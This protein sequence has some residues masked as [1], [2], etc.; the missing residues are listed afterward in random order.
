MITQLLY[1]TD[2]FK[3]KF[4]FVLFSFF[5]LFF[6]LFMWLIIFCLNFISLTLFT[7]MQEQDGDLLFSSMSLSLTHE[8][9]D[10]K[11][12]VNFP[13]VF[14]VEPH[15]ITRLLLFLGTR[16]LSNFS[17]NRDFDIICCNVLSSKRS[18]RTIID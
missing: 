9:L 10:I 4:V 13:L 5:C 12:T 7:G 18:I 15:V 11:F 2:Q 16:N 6:C 17:F 1:R 14:L 8:H 3:A